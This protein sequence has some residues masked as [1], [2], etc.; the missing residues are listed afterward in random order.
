[1]TLY[2]AELP[3]PTIP[4]PL[5]YGGVLVWQPDRWRLLTAEARGSGVAV[6]YRDGTDRGEMRTS[7]AGPILRELRWL[8][9]R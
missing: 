8:Y 1:M 9:R 2:L 4:L 5:D 7:G 6:E 3:P